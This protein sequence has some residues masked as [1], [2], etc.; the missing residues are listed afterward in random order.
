MAAVTIA[1]GL[2]VTALSLLCW[3]GQLL[4]LVA[5]DLAT[6]LGLIED[7]ADVEPVFW[8]DVRGE[9]LWDV[10][11]LWSLVVAGVLLLV[12]SDAWAYFGLAGGGAYLY[13]TGRGIVVRVTMM[14]RGFRVGGAES[15][16]VGLIALAVWGVMAAIT[17]TASVFELAAT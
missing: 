8:A 5:P 3:G 17:V 11:T 10:A 4:S 6:K 7:E 12:G 1:W 13:F 16:R 15:A 14:R 2:V 9:A